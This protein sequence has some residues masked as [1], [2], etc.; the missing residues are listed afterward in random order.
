MPITPIVAIFL[1]VTLILVWN[2]LI[3][4]RYYK[5]CNIRL[6]FFKLKNVIGFDETKLNFGLE[7]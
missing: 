3:Q 5:I 2:M 1:L 7:D 4:R 6:S